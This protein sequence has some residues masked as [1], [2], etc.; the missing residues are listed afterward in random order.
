[1]A[2]CALWPEVGQIALAKAG[3]G[4]GAASAPAMQAVWA[5]LLLRLWSGRGWLVK[6]L[7][8]ADTWWVLVDLCAG[9]G[10]T[11]GTV[12]DPSS[13]KRPT[14]VT[15]AGALTSCSTVGRTLGLATPQCAHV[16]SEGTRQFLPWK[17]L[18]RGEARRLR[19]GAGP[20]PGLLRAGGSVR[21]AVGAHAVLF[22]IPRPPRASGPRA[23]ILQPPASTTDGHMPTAGEGAK[24][25][26][27]R[28]AHTGRGRLQGCPVCLVQ[29]VGVSLRREGGWPAS[30]KAWWGGGSGSTSARA[31]EARG[32]PPRAGPEAA[33]EKLGFAGAPESALSVYALLPEAHRCG[34][35]CFCGLLLDMLSGVGWRLQ[36]L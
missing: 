21:P 34:R 16:P 30:A 7:A 8:S 24:G 1:M 6:S 4:P 35:G 33:M 13:E 25:R 14:H 23:S 20:G 17:V 22:L 18:W 29:P 19:A 9:P 5:P 26:C 3:E 27:E 10:H 2:A 15:S 36:A 28:R 12:A 31:G 32:A 11:G